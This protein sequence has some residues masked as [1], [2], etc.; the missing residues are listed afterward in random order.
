[1]PASGLAVRSADDLVAFVFSLSYSAPHL[2]GARLADFET[3][4]RVLLRGTS[5][6]GVFAERLPDTEILIGT[7]PD[8]T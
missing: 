7:K 4:L 8:P 2:Y 6:D 3:D 1:V 5:P